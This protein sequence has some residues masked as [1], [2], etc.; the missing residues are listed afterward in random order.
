MDEEYCAIKAGVISAPAHERLSE[1]Q[2][3][4]QEWGS[5]FMAC[6]SEQIGPSQGSIAR[7]K[8]CQGDV[9]SNSET[10]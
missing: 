6:Y 7:E 8:V 9:H 3:T 2:I 4:D 1:N 10:S 5:R